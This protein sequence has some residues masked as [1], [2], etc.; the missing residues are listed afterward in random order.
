MIPMSLGL[1]EGSEQNAPLGR[2]VIGGHG[3]RRPS[4]R[5]WSCRPS[6]RSCWAGPRTSLPRST[7]TTR[8]AR[9][10]TPSTPTAGPTSTSRQTT[11]AAAAPTATGGRTPC[12]RQRLSPRTVAVV[13]SPEMAR[14]SS[15]LALSPG[16]RLRARRPR[17]HVGEPQGRRGRR[18]RRQDRRHQGRPARAARHPDDGRS[19]RGRSRRSK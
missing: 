3:P 9:T 15:A 5:C 1:E 18:R 14:R 13:D 4:P 8:R 2:A 16:G 12:R 10:T 7:R 17:R 6:S 19:S 11:D